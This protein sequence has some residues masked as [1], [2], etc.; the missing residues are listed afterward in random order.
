MVG[1]EG[2]NLAVRAPSPHWPPASAAA[3]GVTVP[4]MRRYLPKL[5]CAGDI[6]FGDRFGEPVR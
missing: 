1:V 6:G 5:L 3:R 4:G 2:E